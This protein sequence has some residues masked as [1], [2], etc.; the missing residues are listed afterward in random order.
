MPTVEFD[1]TDPSASPVERYGVILNDPFI[2][3]LTDSTAKGS[4]LL[5]VILPQDPDNP[6]VQSGLN[7][8]FS[9][10]LTLEDL[11]TIMRVITDRAVATGVIPLPGTLKVE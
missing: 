6:F 4:F 11:T 8:A 10:D 5:K 1:Y 3:G 7:F 9:V 2:L